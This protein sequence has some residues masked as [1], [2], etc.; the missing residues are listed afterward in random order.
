[1]STS[2]SHLSFFTASTTP[3]ASG[4]ESNGSL[5]VAIVTGVVGGVST[6]VVIGLV[7]YLLVQRRRQ[8][9]QVRQAGSDTEKGP[10]ITKDIPPLPAVYYSK[11]EFSSWSTESLP[12]ARPAIKVITDLS[13]GKTLPKSPSKPTTPKWKL[14][15]VPVPR[16]SRLPPSPMLNRVH[17]RLSFSRSSRSSS[18]RTTKIDAVPPVPVLPSPSL[19]PTPVPSVLVSVPAGASSPT[20]PFP[21]SAFSTPSVATPSGSLPPTTLAIPTSAFPDPDVPSSAVFPL[22]TL[23][24]AFPSPSLFSSPVGTMPSAHQRPAVS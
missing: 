1:M 4:S 14:K 9:K 11:G 13:T 15:R 10:A 5:T 8:R 22:Y 3:V 12:P 2:I 20:N 17:S 7:I 16:L 6:C 19:P 23:S 18:R 24:P 21:S